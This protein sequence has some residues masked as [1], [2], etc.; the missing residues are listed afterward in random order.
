MLNLYDLTRPELSLLLQSWGFRDVHTTKLW[1]YLYRELVDSVASMHE[2]PPKLRVKLAEEAFVPGIGLGRETLADDGQ[3][4]KY[5]LELHDGLRVETVQMHCRDR[6]TACLSSQVGCALGCVFCATGQMGFTRDLMASEIVAQAIFVERALRRSGERLRNLVLM[7]MGEPLMN[8][9][10]VTTA[11]DILREPSSL[12]IGAKQMTISTV[13]VIPSIIRLADEGRPYSLAVSLHAATQAERLKLLPAARPWPLADLI[14]ACRYY[15][16]RLQQKIFF[17]WTLIAGVNDSADLAR[18]LAELLHDLP[19]QVNLIPLNP[20]AGFA[21]L[22][23]RSEAMRDFQAILKQH[24]LPSTVRQRRG[25]EIAAG[26]GQ[27]AISA[28]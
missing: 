10:A 12:A 11:L 21:A 24:G 6:A 15:T 4:R 26:C 25:I 18:E 1:S 20:T 17:E 27:L 28:T 7:G 3:T 16:S 2:L 9:E 19:A 13:G 22:P 14:D 5:L 8:Y 23:G